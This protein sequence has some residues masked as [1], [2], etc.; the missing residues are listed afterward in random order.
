MIRH[1]NFEGYLTMCKKIHL[2]VLKLSPKVE[3]LEEILG[4]HL[5]QI[6]VMEGDKA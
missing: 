4:M 6:L 3:G 1:N 5:D 2:T